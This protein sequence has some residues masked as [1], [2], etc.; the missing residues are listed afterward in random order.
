MNEPRPDTRN[1]RVRRLHVARL[2]W[3]DCYWKPSDERPGGWEHGDPCVAFEGDLIEYE[4]DVRAD[5]TERLR[6]AYE[7]SAGAAPLESIEVN[8]HQYVH[9]AACPCQPP[10]KPIEVD[11]DAEGTDR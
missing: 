3:G 1:R 10:M 4:N 7:R 8:G 5:F 6:L 9:V 2:K 11:W